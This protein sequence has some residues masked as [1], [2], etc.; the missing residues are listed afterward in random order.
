MNAETIIATGQLQA[1]IENDK[2][3]RRAVRKAIDYFNYDQADYV[4]DELQKRYPKTWTDLYSYIVTIPLA[5]TLASQRAKLFQND[6]VITIDAESEPIQENFNLLLDQTNLYF[7]LSVLDQYAETC[8]QVAAIPRWDARRKMV[9][10]EIITPDK[11]IVIQ[12]PDRP[13]EPRAVAYSVG[14]Y[15]DTNLNSRV[16]KYAYWTDEEYAVVTFKSDYTIDKYIEAPVPNTYGRIPIVWFRTD[17]PIDTFFLENGYPIMNCNERANIQLTSLDIGTDYQA[18]ATMVTEGLPEGKIIK[19]AVTRYIN[20]PLGDDLKPVGRAYFINPSVDLKQIWEIINQNIDLYASLMGIST[21]AIK[22]G[23]AFSSGYQLR[24]SKSDIIDYN[25]KK[26]SMYRESVRQLVQLTM[27]CAR[28]YGG[29]AMPEDAG[30]GI[31]FADVTVETNPLEQEQIRGL[32]ITNGTM[33]RIDAIMDDNPDLTREQ[34][35]ETAKRIDADNRIF[36]VGGT[37]GLDPV[38]FDE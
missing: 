20:F 17:L 18:F 33:S 10:I 27:D 7:V 1:K 19:A 35:E 8:N 32:K 21:Q 11:V 14:V 25:N 12:D 3:R 36:K 9:Y 26:R 15:T 24:L 34:A 23:T 38:L 6:P 31:D 16:D 28:L 30:I 13:T 4:A 29:Q 22:Q 2:L 37:D 5:R